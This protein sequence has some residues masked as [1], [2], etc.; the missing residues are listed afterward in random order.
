MHKREAAGGRARARNRA[1]DKQVSSS[2]GKGRS[3]TPRGGGAQGHPVLSVGTVDE[4]RVIRV[5][6]ISK[7]R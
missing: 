5:W 4:G 2:A 6:Y 3:R 1:K 7:P